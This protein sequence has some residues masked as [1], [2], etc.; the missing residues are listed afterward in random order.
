MNSEK[1]Y[2]ILLYTIAGDALGTPL[3]GLSKGH[4]ASTLKEINGYAD[5]LPAL[6]G[7]TE[8]WKKP[9][10]Y[11][12]ISQFIIL[13]SMVSLSGHFSV[14]RYK[15]AAALSPDFSDTG[16]GIFRYPENAVRSFIQNC[17][18]GNMSV[19]VTALPSQSLPLLVLHLGLFSETRA[20]AI[21]NS[22]ELAKHVTSDAASIAG[23]ALYAALIWDFMSQKI[24]SFNDLPHAASE[25]AAESVSFFKNESP[26]V[27]AAGLNPD[28]LVRAAALY[29]EAF[30][31]A[32]SHI[33]DIVNSCLKTPA[34]RL[35]I[36]HPLAL[37]PY[38]IHL[39]GSSNGL[40]KIAQEG[41]ST[42]VLTAL[43]GSF[44]AL[45]RPVDELPAALVDGLVNRKRLL[46]IVGAI[47][48]GSAPDR[49]VGEFMD[50]ELSLTAKAFEELKAKN[51]N[52]EPKKKAKTGKIE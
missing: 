23:A 2:N 41:G 21:L 15:E 18:S 27:F 12:Y 7:K 24:S 39:S 52:K 11:S 38:A 42:A 49:L 28:S 44:I 30:A 6:K 25:S 47:S 45:T 1:I 34:S 22:C 16:L 43:A 40:F 14:K 4:I 36:P 50:S 48:N 51:K 20:Q 13:F 10:L 46:S 29:A 5:P 31:G 19:P 32:E 33:L 9:G 37:M 17:F 8:R 35:T 26:K 3:D